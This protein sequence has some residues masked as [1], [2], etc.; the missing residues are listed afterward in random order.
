MAVLIRPALRR[1]FSD[2]EFLSL[3]AMVDRLTGG[4]KLPPPP[5]GPLCDVPLTV[6]R[7]CDLV[8]TNRVQHR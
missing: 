4:P 1:S 5:D 6:G 2:L 3:Q 8:L 7:A